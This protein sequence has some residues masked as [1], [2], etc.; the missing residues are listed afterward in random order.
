MI[1]KEVYEEQKALSDRWKSMYYEKKNEID[2]LT[3]N[4]NKLEEWVKNEIEAIMQ[5]WGRQITDIGCLDIQMT[6]KNYGNV[7][8]KMKEIKENNDKD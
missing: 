3:N 2:Q 7:L 5:K 6:I 1:T 8:N 4:W